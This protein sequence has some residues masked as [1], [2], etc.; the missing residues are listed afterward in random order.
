MC[1]SVLGQFGGSVNEKGISMRFVSGSWAEAYRTAASAEEVGTVLFIDQGYD[2][3]C[4]ATLAVASFNVGD[5]IS[6]RG[7]AMTPRIGLSCRECVVWWRERSV[8]L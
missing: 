1:S 5:A 2:L 4:H 7:T 3:C 6:W 8:V